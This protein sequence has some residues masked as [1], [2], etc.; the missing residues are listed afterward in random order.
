MAIMNQ[1]ERPVP[2]LTLERAVL[3]VPA[4]NGVL[5]DV[6]G[7]HLVK[8]G[9]DELADDALLVVSELVTN[10]ITAAPGRP[11]WFRMA[12]W[13]HVLAIEVRDSSPEW[14]LRREPGLRQ[15]FLW[16]THRRHHRPATPRDHH[17]L[18]L[19]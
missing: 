13:P 8:W 9:L 14:A 1:E 3:A 2:G 11:L 16:Q 5:R 15:P 17:S 4:V 18:W 12:R 6:A 7:V 19:Q 10:A